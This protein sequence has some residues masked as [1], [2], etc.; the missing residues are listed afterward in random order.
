MDN[1]TIRC[2][3][4]KIQDTH[5]FDMATFYKV[6]MVL[7]ILLAEKGG[8][9]EKHVLTPN[10]IKEI[11][12]AYSLGKRHK[13]EIELTEDE[14]DFICHWF[15][16]MIGSSWSVNGINKYDFVSF[17]KMRLKDYEG[18]HDKP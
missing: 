4:P 10:D 5:K 15:C 9:S 18:Q 2:V 1:Q 3:T 7:H 17:T 16:P 8:Y 11:F 14:I 12:D 6:R 13:P